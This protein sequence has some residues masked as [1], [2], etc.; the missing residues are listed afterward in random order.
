[1]NRKIFCLL[2][3][4]LL[5]ITILSGCFEGDKNKIS[6]SGNENNEKN[7]EK[8]PGF[9]QQLIN[10]AS[11]GD[12]IYIPSG[13][14]NESIVINKTINLIG[15]DK[16]TTIIDSTGYG[17]ALHVSADYVKISGFTI[18]KNKTSETVI[19]KDV[20]DFPEKIDPI[21]N[22]SGTPKIKIGV[23]IES[24]NNIISDNIFESISQTGYGIRIMFGKNTTISNNIFKNNQYG[25]ELRYSDGNTISNNQFTNN[26]YGASITT[27]VNNYI[28]LNNLSSNYY[29]IVI[30][31]GRENNISF[32]NFSNHSACSLGLSSSN[33][34]ICN[35]S[36]F[37][38]GL[39]F[40][41][42]C[43]NSI[44]NNTVNNKPLI[45]LENI[46]NTTIEQKAGQITLINCKNIT[47]QDQEISNVGWSGIQIYNSSAC[48]IKFNNISNNGYGLYI[49][50][51]SE[52]N[53]VFN[54]TI[55][56]NRNVGIY[57]YSSS[58][59][60]LK[61]NVI[62]NNGDNSKIIHPA[63]ISLGALSNENIISENTI[64]FNKN[65]GLDVGYSHYNQ[66]SGNL[67]ETNVYYGIWIR[68]ADN[69]TVCENNIITNQNGIIFSTSYDNQ[70]YMNNFISNSLNVKFLE[71]VNN[72]WDN[73][74]TGNYWDDYNGTDNNDDGIGDTPYNI[75]GSNNQDKY[76]LIDPY[77]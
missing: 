54:N 2:I 48:K 36:F 19:S 55:M 46:S 68:Y 24:D 21:I 10:N 26:V 53:L 56:S 59:N 72:T 17:E 69:N 61:Y 42:I 41:N 3:S 22:F 25:L 45:F 73:G 6:N 63:G 74:S 62:L 65:S 15:E 12:T 76:P 7:G 31:G 75:T 47:I 13:I 28:N 37:N 38:D 52:N 20:F 14:Y 33:N 29:G 16:N 67:I 18:S 43:Q 40:M 49:S 70:L 66:I 34:Q 30:E 27:G 11:S 51:N 32:N 60:T 57:L 39:Y 5:L 50:S 8:S 4:V 1:M 23:L 77:N 64:A 71:T 44:K 9:I 58:N 35:N